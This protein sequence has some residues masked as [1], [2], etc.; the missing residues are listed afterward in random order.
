MAYYDRV[1]RRWESL[2]E[3]M[4]ESLNPDKAWE[5]LHSHHT[6]PKRYVSPN[7]R[8]NPDINERR[9][10]R[11][12]GNNPINEESD[13]FYD[14]LSDEEE[15]KYDDK[16]RRTKQRAND[17]VEK[18]LRIREQE[19]RR[20]L[21]TIRNTAENDAQHKFSTHRI[22]HERTLDPFPIID[23]PVELR[24]Y[25]KIYGAYY[26]NPR[27]IPLETGGNKKI[28]DL[29]LL[30]NSFVQYTDIPKGNKQST[31]TEF[32]TNSPIFNHKAYFP[33]S[34][35]KDLVELLGKSNFLFEVWDQVSTDKKTI[36]G[37]SK[38][39]LSCFYQSLVFRKN[40]L[41]NTSYFEYG[42]N[43]YPMVGFDDNADIIDFD[44]KRVGWLKMVIALGSPE[45]VNLFDRVRNERDITRVED[46]SRSRPRD[47]IKVEDRTRSS[48]R[49][50]DIIRVE[51]RSRSRPRDRTRSEP[52]DRSR[53]EPRDRDRSRSRPR[54]TIRVEDRTRSR[55][56]DGTRSRPRPRDRS[57]HREEEEELKIRQVK[58]KQEGGAYVSSTNNEEVE[59]LMRELIDTI[60]D[61]SGGTGKR[62]KGQWS[63][64]QLESLRNLFE[65][66]RLEDC[67]DIIAKVFRESAPRSKNL[68]KTINMAHFENGLID[69]TSLSR[70]AISNILK[71][72]DYRGSYD[73]E[74]L[75]HCYLDYCR[76]GNYAEDRVKRIF[77]KLHVFFG[78]SENNGKFKNIPR[79]YEKDSVLKNKELAAM[80]CRDKG[81]R[82][83]LNIIIDLF[84]AN[85]DRE[86]N[87]DLQ[88]FLE[89]V[90][91]P[92]LFEESHI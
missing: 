11:D 89:F 75:Q 76:N 83:G 12:F 64:N 39:S 21:D 41:L 63:D 82:D 40:G 85:G 90:R 58:P 7:F 60:K 84:Q 32:N 71:I 65:E 38:V 51:N 35:G 55:P 9:D 20:R 8:T 67:K 10:R 46:R 16:R 37:F 92:P 86:K 81:L 69:H 27:D 56:R 73:L 62:G 88:E 77:E 18:M 59:S 36:V 4:N 42:A 68:I 72:W 15:E 3:M 70:K 45:Q 31:S 34:V 78:L 53:S 48:S 44:G 47:I 28:S 19:R 26:M 24:L 22:S 50:R 13:D 80:W 61:N 52:R 14:Y 87:I 6:S 5:I 49:P 54:E 30:R 1:Q 2:K 17:D 74:E 91:N 57:R 25:L 43:Q 66:C 33:I 29:G 23:E 79:S